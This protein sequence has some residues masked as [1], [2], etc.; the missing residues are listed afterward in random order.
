M[1]KYIHVTK[2]VRESLAKTFGVTGRTVYNAL[3]FAE[4]RGDSDL[5]KRMRV[6][7]FKNGG[8]L[9]N[10]LPACETLYDHDGYM[11]QY[12]R[13]GSI[14]LEFSFNDAD[15]TVYHKGEKVRHYEHVVVSDIPVIQQYAMTL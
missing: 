1:K 5:A 8:I 15:C 12:L 9:M 13:N 14:L 2:D 7:A 3:N 6:F 11:R 4:R 10:E